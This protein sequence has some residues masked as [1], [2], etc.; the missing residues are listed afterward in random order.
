[1]ISS[2]RKKSRPQKQ[3]SRWSLTALEQRLMLAGDVA[4]SQPSLEPAAAVSMPAATTNNS[5]LVFV[6]PSVPNLDQIVNELDQPYE[7][8]LLDANRSGLDQMTEAL[9]GRSN[10]RSMHV[11]AHGEVGQIK[12]GDH[13]IDQQA[14]VAAQE[15]IRSWQSA[16]T[17]DADI[18]IYSC[19]TGEGEIGKQFVSQLSRLSGA[20]VAASID[21]T[22]GMLAGGDWDLERVT[23]TIEASLALGTQLRDRFEGTLGISI[24]AAGLTGEEQ[25]DLIVDGSVVQTF[26]V[27]GNA[28]AGQF[29][30][31]NYDVDGVDVNDVRIAFTN[32]FFDPDNSI[33]RNLRVDQITIDGVVYQTEDPSVFSTGT[34]KPGGVVAGFVENEF[35]HTNGYFQYSDNDPAAGSLISITAQG[36]E[37]DENISLLIDGVEVQSWS[38][39]GTGVDQYIHQ[40]DSTVSADQIRVA[41]TN[42]FFD[43]PNGIDR[44]VRVDQIAVDGSVYQSEAPTVWSTGTWISG[45]GIT[46]GFHQRDVLHGNGYFQYEA[47]PATNPGEIGLTL[48]A[49]TID[50]DTGVLNFVV[51]RGGGTDGT[52]TVDYETSSG[53]ADSSDYTPISGTLTFADGVTGQQVSLNINDDSLPEA[54]ESFSL[55]LSNPTGGATLAAITTQ[56]VTIHDDDENIGGEIF[57][58]SFESVSGWTTE[59]FDND[60]T[61]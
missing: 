37:G 7:L 10:V 12:L 49:L 46:P 51:F 4:A 9:K 31:Y 22:G 17:T 27:G 29:E 45:L 47:G 8:V 25:M 33:D 32:D 14:L 39:I 2:L 19:N 13:V 11:I 35:L 6:D 24:R 1:M 28:Y 3:Q 38:G 41:F 58:D 20:D 16:L 26:T 5:D 42:D 40:A 52:V 23:G 44:N 30:T 55:T 21:K 56:V 15:A 34:W 57:E 61:T 54:D 59:P 50:E 18:L 43:A 60:T 48:D 53:S 36:F